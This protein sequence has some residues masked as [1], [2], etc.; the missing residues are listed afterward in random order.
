MHIL[1]LVVLLAIFSCEKKEAQ[2]GPTPTT[3]VKLSGFSPTS[4][5]AG[6]TVI[7]LGSSFNESATGNNVKFNGVTATIVSATAT[8]LIVT[9]PTA[10]STGKISVTVEG[11]T[12][13]SVD[14][15]VVLPSI[16]SFAPY[17]G[18]V[19]SEV[20]LSGSGFNGSTSVVKFNGV[21][22]NIL[23]ASPTQV[24]VTVPATATT[25]PITVT[26]SGSTIVS[27][28]DFQI[29]T[30]SPI[31]VGNTNSSLARLIATDPSGNV[32]IGGAL[33]TSLTI[34]SDVMTG[35]GTF[36]AKYD[37][38]L[39]PIWAR[40]VE[41]PTGFLYLQD[42]VVDAS[43]NTYIAGH[44]SNGQVTFGSLTTGNF[45]GDDVFVAKL[46]SSGTFVWVAH[47]G[48]SGDDRAVG[49]ALDASGNVYATG[50]HS[51]TITF[52]S[53][54]QLNGN[55]IFVTKYNT[56][57]G[58]VTLAMS[59]PSTGINVGDCI[60]VDGSGNILVGATYTGTIT[61][62]TSTHVT[63]SMSGLIFKTTNDGV[64]MWS[65]SFA[66]SNG[67]DINDLAID[68]SG[69]PYVVG[70][71]SGAGTLILSGAS[72]SGSSYDGFAFM[73]DGATGA[74]IWKRTFG[75]AYSDNAHSIVVGESG[76]CY[77]T[78][79]FDKLAHFGEFTISTSQNGVNDAFVLKIDN[80]TIPWAVST[81][82]VGSAEGYGV[83]RRGLEVIAVGR[84]DGIV[85]F[86]E[87]ELSAPN[88]NVFIWRIGQ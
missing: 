11:K 34:G 17:G 70:S 52:G 78:G 84:F 10:A 5:K 62:G 41:D 77:V 16:T 49:L 30:S 38:N 66:G 42:L 69:N 86:G 13:I 79:Q 8:T 31:R 46:N 47:D 39:N 71:F 14:D 21:T 81:D 67:T 75:G 85:A 6:T 25:G 4:G 56:S 37:A 40:N 18:I 65:I 73:L 87:F 53:A 15:F 29:F 72:T 22:A 35:S 26:S 76:T 54:A 68:N 59:Y 36:V 58:E 43:G 51:N 61:L 23:L 7:L 48:S 60:K 1:R 9:V 27:E 74:T 82:G 83:S 64:P 2:P 20:N 44:F 57:N 28:D 19:G 55:G 33:S 50:Y 24:K 80:G 12:S 45:G 88:N 3:P 32:Y 63:N